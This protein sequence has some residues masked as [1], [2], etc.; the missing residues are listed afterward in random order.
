M[1]EED[2]KNAS[3]EDSTL[4]IK[5]PKMS[6][7]KVNPWIVST[8]ILLIFSMLIY[9]RPQMFGIGGATGAATAA[10]PSDVISLEQAGQDAVDYINTN[11]VQGEAEVTVA[12]TEE[13][14]ENMYKITTDFQGN[15]IDVYIT[16]DGKWLFVS[17][18][19][20]ITATVPTTQTTPTTQPP[21]P[22]VVKTDRPE[23]RAFVM[24]HCPYGLQFIKA[25]V[26]VIELLGDKADFYLNFVN[27]AM[28][29]ETEVYEQLRMYCI[30]TEQ[31][32]KFTNYLRCFVEAGESEACLDEVGV[33]KDAL[34]TCMDATDDEY[35]IADTLAAGEEAWGS[36]FPPFPIDDALNSQYG[37]RGSPTFVL[38][39]QVVSVNRSP[40]AIKD[41]VCNAFNT[42]PEECETEL[43]TTAE[44]PGFGAMGTGGGDAGSGGACG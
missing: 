37:V 43:S 39:G 44:S 19:F 21:A 36:R 8:V 28:H 13:F 4:T 14:N 6:M 12:S 3:G 27:Y 30:K 7:P 31:N 25:Y 32:D 24:S 34:Q 9:T 33:D 26:P 22:E 23:V 11:L 2:K 42:P 17:A 16:K 35:G 1:A 38:N 5:L 41:A 18:P 10:D 20:D 29:G 40:E 15:N